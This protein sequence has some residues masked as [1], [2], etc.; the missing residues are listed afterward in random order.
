MESP[1][2]MN[3]LGISSTD[4]SHTTIILIPSTSSRGNQKHKRYWV[5]KR[6][7]M[8]TRHIPSQMLYD[9]KV[10]L[11]VRFAMQIGSAI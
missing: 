4:K 2:T 3:W 5:T 7:A 8:P 11:R 6:N 1:V 9:V 10:F